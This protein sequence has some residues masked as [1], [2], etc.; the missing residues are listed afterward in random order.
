MIDHPDP[1][2]STTRCM[3]AGTP[4][5]WLAESSARWPG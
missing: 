5:C 3:P 1:L 4:R 2:R